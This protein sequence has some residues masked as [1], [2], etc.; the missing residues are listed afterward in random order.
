MV[1]D[2]VPTCRISVFHSLVDVDLCHHFQKTM[3]CEKC[4]KKLKQS[5]MTSGKRSEAEGGMDKPGANKL[6]VNKAARFS[7]YQLQKSRGKCKLCKNMVHMV[8][9]SLVPITD[10]LSAESRL[11]PNVRVQARRV[12]HVRGEAVRHDQLQDDRYVIVVT[13]ATTNTLSA[14]KSLCHVQVRT[15]ATVLCH[16]NQL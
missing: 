3:V 1:L 7:P 15:I 16:I 9:A 10:S 6:L 12:L 8:G 2:G 11:L 5:A 13:F 4:E 14:N